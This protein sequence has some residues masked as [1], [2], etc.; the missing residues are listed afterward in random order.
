[1]RFSTDTY[2]GDRE[3]GIWRVSSAGG[4]PRTECAKRIST[5]SEGLWRLPCSLPPSSPPRFIATEWV[6]GVTF[7][8]VPSRLLLP[9]MRS[10]GWHPGERARR[11]CLRGTQRGT[12]R[13]AYSMCSVLDPAEVCTLHNASMPKQGP[14]P[15]AHT[16]H[17]IRAERNNGVYFVTSAL[18]S[19]LLSRLVE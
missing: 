5:A 7:G 2:D 6:G 1:M 13:L 15:S 17:A 18:R 11:E 19:M 9:R 14:R 12:L 4:S 10:E 8:R 16:R 3:G